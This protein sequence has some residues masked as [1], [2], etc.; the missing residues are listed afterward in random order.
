MAAN[1]L[2]KDLIVPELP[3][4]IAFWPKALGWKILVTCAFCVL[5]YVG[6]KVIRR[7][8]KN[9]YRREGLQTL[10]QLNFDLNSGTSHLSLCSLNHCL[11]TVAAKAYG[12]TAVASLYGDDW[13]SFLND[14]SNLP[15]NRHLFERFQLTLLMPETRNLL[16]LEEVR[17]LIQF[18]GDW[19]AHHEVNNDIRI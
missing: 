14:T 10:T 5:I 3:T 9:R 8:H 13:I 1:P 4:T 7:W 2:L 11:K 6:I 16:S 12:S 15:F 19:I 18:S 17:V